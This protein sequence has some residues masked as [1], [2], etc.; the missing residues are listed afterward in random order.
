MSKSVDV[1]L[2]AWADELLHCGCRNAS[3]LSRVAVLA[4]IQARIN[5]RFS[6]DDVQKLV[7][8]LGIIMERKRKVYPG[9]Q[10]SADFPMMIGEFT[11]MY[12]EVYKQDD[13][14]L[15]HMV[16]DTLVQELRDPS[17]GPAR[18]TN[19]TLSANNRNRLSGKQSGQQACS[20]DGSMQDSFKSM[21]MDCL[22]QRFF[23]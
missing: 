6:P 19:K 1:K 10:T 3:E 11:R 13:L 21:I 17:V 15:A 4:T 22:A 14:P 7:K 2:E 23:G 16:S 20:I 18:G 12:P 8:K 5:Q 9:E